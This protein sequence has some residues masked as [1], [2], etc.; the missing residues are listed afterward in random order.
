VAALFL[1]PMSTVIWARRRAEW[2]RF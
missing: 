2:Q 1:V